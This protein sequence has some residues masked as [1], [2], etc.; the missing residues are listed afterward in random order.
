MATETILSPG[1][2]LQ[3]TDKSFISP[4]VDPSGM[5]IIGPTAKG[6]VEIPTTIKNYSDFKQIFGTTVQNG[7]K[8][9]EYFT[10]LAVKNYFENGGSSAIVVR[11]VS[12]SFTSA[13]STRISGSSGSTEPFTLETLGQGSSFNNTHAGSTGVA[14]INFSFTGEI[15]TSSLELS[16]ANRY[17]RITSESHTYG[18]GNYA[19]VFSGSNNYDPTLEPAD[20]TIIKVDLVDSNADG[21]TGKITAYSASILLSASLEAHFDT[22]EN[23]EAFAATDFNRGN[24]GFALSGSVADPVESSSFGD[25]EVSVFS[26]LTSFAKA[27]KLRQGVPVSGTFSN[28][29][30]PEGSV[31]NFR[32]EIK[33]VNNTQGTFTLIIRRGDDTTANPLVLETFTECSLDPLSDNYIAKKIGDT[34]STVELDT[35]TGDYVVTTTGEF[36]N[37]SNFVRVSAVNR[38]TYRYLDAQGNVG[39][40]SADKS[41]SGS[42]PLVQ[43]GSFKDALGTLLSSDANNNK[44]G[45][46]SGT[47]VDNIQ[48]LHTGSYTKAISLLKNKEDYKYKTLIVPGFNQDTH[49]TQIDDIIENTTQR[50]D[51]FFVTDLEVWGASVTEVTDESADLD[52]SFAATYWPWVQV[53]SSEL[54]RNI[55]CPASTIIP[56]VY[57]KN[58]SLAAPWFAP[59]GET[60]GKMGRL[61]TGVEKK[62]SKANRD[63]LYSAKINPIASFPEGLLIFGQKTLQNAKSALDRVNVRRMLLDVK[64]TI[65]GFA[66]DVLFE[67]NTEQ[68]RDRFIRRATPYLE[69]LVQRQ[70]LYAFQIKMDGQNN[71]PDVI[72]EN[73]LVGQVFLQPTKTAEFIVIDFTLTRTGASFTD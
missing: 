33:D 34:N 57:A 54:N 70:G 71:T 9:E 50:G 35:E 31:D 42:L 68:T 17:I 51:S 27:T 26:G 19:V 41:Y 13:A 2:L 4:G 23:T 67:N 49:A 28:G 38:P 37:K 1:V 58:D 43:S 56:G 14:K 12:G 66:D 48:G 5:A 59:A 61:V 6:P 44:F 21:T 7:N 65:G 29:G 20:H 62:L 39:L 32:W 60:R 45:S 16:S 55:W 15:E 3:E 72:D 40:D 30:L 10:H 24:V 73:K 8:R 36:E 46:A 47:S 11:V 18:T 69:S 25:I 53:Y 64:D 63:T 52:T 22:H